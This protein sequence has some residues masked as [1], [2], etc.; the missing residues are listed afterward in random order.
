MIDYRF[1]HQDRS[2]FRE[3]VGQTL[4]GYFQV[5]CFNVFNGYHSK[6]V[7]VDDELELEL[8]ELVEVEELDDEVEEVEVL[9]EVEVEVEVEV[10]VKAAYFQAEF[11]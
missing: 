10:L 11:T 8:V 3:S 9:V 7:L 2:P 6:V 1:F 4:K 5:L